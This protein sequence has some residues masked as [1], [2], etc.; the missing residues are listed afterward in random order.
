MRQTDSRRGLWLPVTVVLAV[1]CAAARRWQLS[2]AFEGTL[3]LPCPFAPASIVLV[4]LLVLSTAVLF[5]LA[6]RQPVAPSLDRD[7]ELAV[8]AA[9]DTLFLAALVAAAFLALMAAP[10]LFSRGIQ[11]WRAF[12]TAGQ[13]GASVRGMD[14]GLLLL[15]TALT[16]LLAFVGLL[17]SAKAAYRNTSGRMAILLPAVNGCLWL[18]AIYRANAADP[19][20]WN[21]SPLLLAIVCGM[22]FCLAC[23]GLSAGAAHPRRALWLAAMTVVLSAAALAGRWDRG[24]ALLLASQLVC[25]LAFLL[26]VPENLIQPPEPAAQPARAEEKLEEDTHE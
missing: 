7:P 23:A 11:L 19:V 2:T 22:L 1:L 17:L 10:F 6:W 8:S 25:A 18:M 4:I 16:S 5:L 9:G 21:Y 24:S 3:Q 26:R 13:Y 20:R 15:L 14:N 12:Q